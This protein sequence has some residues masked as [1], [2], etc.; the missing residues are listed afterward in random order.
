MTT[1]VSGYTLYAVIKQNDEYSISAFGFVC[2]TTPT[3]Y[4]FQ[5][6]KDTHFSIICSDDEELNIEIIAIKNLGSNS[7]NKLAILDYLNNDKALEN[8]SIKSIM[9]FYSKHIK[10]NIVDNMLVIKNSTS[11]N[12]FKSIINKNLETTEL[13]NVYNSMQIVELHL[14]INN[15]N[16]QLYISNPSFSIDK[17]S[18][19]YLLV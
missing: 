8:D 6:L 2:S 12:E 1:S 10:S 17:N 7:A 15:Y 11:H 13:N 18:M 9:K 3:N 14:L 4:I 5:M 16:K 19:N